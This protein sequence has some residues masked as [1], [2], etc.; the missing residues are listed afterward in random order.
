MGAVVYMPKNA[1]HKLQLTLACVKGTILKDYH[2]TPLSHVISLLLESLFQTLFSNNNKKK[3][4][5]ISHRR[6]KTRII[7]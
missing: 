7:K 2:D 1:E 5:R 6:A 3:H 4:K